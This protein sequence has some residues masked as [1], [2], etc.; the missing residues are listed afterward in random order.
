M[1]PGYRALHDSAALLDLSRRGRI[2]V[3]GDDRARLLHAMTTNH[4]QQL[5]PGQWLYAFFLD[6]QGRIQAD[7]NIVCYPDYLLLDVEPERRHF[8]M[9]HLDKYIIAD[10]VTLEDAT[11]HTWCLAVEGPQAGNTPE[12][13]FPISYTGA[14]GYRLY[15]SGGRP[16]ID[17]VP[18]EL[19]D[20]EVVRLE[21]YKP[22]Y[23]V[24]ITEKTLPQE[25]QQMRAV[26]FQK[27]CYIGQEIVE[28]VRARGHVNR[29][30]MGFK[31]GAAL[32]IPSGEKVFADGKEV[33]EVTSAAANCEEKTFG[34]AMVRVPT[35]A[36]GVRVEIAG[37][38]AT[39][40]MP[41][42]G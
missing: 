10:D 21:H 11:D 20:L 13:G 4:V 6:A 1:T 18:A 19:S 27:G 3:S 8:L 30:L 16:T 7:A 40:H 31:M 17:L 29:L 42:M 35:A 23:G 15:G 9:E 22:R 36:P 37:R 39:L 14:A 12:G 25:S 33:G 26:H 2:H 41:W 38:P 24:D 28:R 32:Q 34:L 5:Q